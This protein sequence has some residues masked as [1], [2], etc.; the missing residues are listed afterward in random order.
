[1]DYTNVSPDSHLYSLYLL[2]VD[3]GAIT[4]SQGSCLTQTNIVGI[5]DLL[6]TQANMPAYTNTDAL[7][8]QANGGN[9]FTDIKTWF[10]R[11]APA[12]KQAFDVG[13][14]LYDVG[15]QVAPIVAPLLGLGG[16]C[17]CGGVHKE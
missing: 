15:K 5:N 9:F 4:L 16:C 13:K 2:V 11:H 1:V 17:D 3:D 8:A 7:I 14:Q 12:F 10:P 6:N